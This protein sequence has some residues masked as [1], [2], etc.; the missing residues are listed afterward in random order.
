MRHVGDEVAA[1]DLE[2]AQLAHVV[3]HEHVAEGL[4]VGAAQPGAVHLEG[5]ALG[6]VERQ[7][8]RDDRAARG[9]RAQRL[10]HLR[11]ARDLDQWPPRAVV[12]GGQGEQLAGA[13]VHERH[14]ADEVGHQHALHHAAQ[15]RLQPLALDAQR[16]DGG[17]HLARH[18]RE[19]RLEDAQVVAPLGRQVGRGRAAGDGARERDQPLDTSEQ[20]AGEDE[21]GREAE[22]HR[23]EEPPDEEPAEMRH[24]LRHRREGQRRAHDAYALAARLPPGGVEE[25]DADRAA[26]TDG[27]PLAGRQRGAELGPVGVVLERLRGARRLAEHTSVRC[28][29]GQADAEVGGE[30]RAGRIELRAGRPGQ[31]LARQ[32]RLGQE[33][34]AERLDLMPLERERDVGDRAH[35]RGGERRQRRQDELED[36]PTAR[37]RRG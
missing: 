19:L 27:S 36:E 21:R 35:E 31:G 15:D 26:L 20:A 3:Q 29:H 30:P 28:D 8:A 5:G 16:R 7:V 18:V 4:P 24:V 9:E 34:L 2:P 14:P 32:A 22:E 1:D 23:G 33:A 11:L 25:P 6:A 17:R 37:A 10:A 13:L 12:A